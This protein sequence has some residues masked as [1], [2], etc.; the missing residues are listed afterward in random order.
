MTPAISIIIPTY[1]RL[2]LL[3]ETL[4]SIFRQT[5]QASE[6]IVVDNGSSDGTVEWLK[7]DAPRQSDRHPEHHEY[8]GGCQEQRPGGGHRGVHQVL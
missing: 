4:Q 3:K 2:E 7:K 6:I 8:S 5:L 1:N